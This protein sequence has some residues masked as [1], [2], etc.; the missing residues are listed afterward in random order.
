M[1]SVSADLSA[2]ILARQRQPKV[3]VRVDWDDDG[4]FTTTGSGYQDDISADVVS[5]D[6]N[7]ELSTDLP[8]QAKLF[9]GAAA[10]QATITLAHRDP[11]GDPIKHGG[12]F[13]SGLNADSPLFAKQR[14]GR[15]VTLEFGFVTAAGTAEYVTVLVGTIRS[16]T[17]SA[18]GRQAIMV[19]ADRTE[20]M[21]K[22]VQL[23]M[24]IADGDLTG[25]AGSNDPASTP[26]GWPTMSPAN[27]ATTP[28][29]P[30][31]LTA[32]CPR[33]CTAGATRVG[34]IQDHHG[35]N[36]SK[37]SYSPTPEFPTAAKWVQA[38]NTD[39]TSGQEIS[40]I[41]SQ[42]AGLHTN[43]GGKMLWE[44]WCKFNTTAADQPFFIVYRTGS[45]FPYCRCIWNTGA[46][47]PVIFVRAGADAV[48]RVAAGPV[49]AP[50]TSAWHYYGVHVAFTTLAPTSRSVTTPPP[51]AR[52]M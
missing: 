3:R 19:V 42:S 38:V 44:G 29:P 11:A 15:A 10:A 45:P 27:V 30:P 16:L 21:R 35:A 46:G 50:G 8:I 51:P 22:Q 6:L 14:K 9:A 17:V 1:Q 2:A 48:A 47:L 26:P 7:R 23:P 52:C 25:T 39:G 40:Y 41:L 18:G 28:A 5:V 34:A 37:L 13:Y 12:W 32:S 20:T 49:V 43:N 24:I 31:G 4:S 36:G 33:P